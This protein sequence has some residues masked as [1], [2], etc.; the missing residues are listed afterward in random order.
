VAEAGVPDAGAYGPCAETQRD[1]SFVHF[2][3]QLP[4]TCSLSRGFGGDNLSVRFQACEACDNAGTLNQ[5]YV[6]INDCDG[7]A[8]V[9]ASNAGSSYRTTGKGC[10]ELSMTNVDLGNTEADRSCIDVYAGVG[11]ATNADFTDGF[12]TIRVCRC[13]RQTGNCVRCNSSTCDGS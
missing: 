7:C 1:C 12:H 2:E 13:N 4:A 8:Q 3:V 11:S 9:Y 6:R 5:Y 10:H